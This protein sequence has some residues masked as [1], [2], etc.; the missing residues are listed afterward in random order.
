MNTNGLLS[1]EKFKHIYDEVFGTFYRLF[2]SVSSETKA[3]LISDSVFVYFIAHYINCELVNKICKDGNMELLLS[4]YSKMYYE[5]DWSAQ[6]VQ[7]NNDFQPANLRWYI[8]KTLRNLTINN[9]HLSLKK[10][11]R[12]IR[13][14]DALGIGWFTWMKAEFIKKH[15]LSIDNTY[16]Q[17]LLNGCEKIHHPMNTK[18]RNSVVVFFDEILQFCQDELRI[19][20]EAKPIR[21][22]WMKRLE[23]LNTVYHF[24]LEKI[25]NRSLQPLLLV[26]AEAKGINKVISQAYRQC[27]KTAIGFQHGNDVGGLFKDVSVYNKLTSYQQF[28]FPT[29]SAAK[30]YEK[31]YKRNPISQFYPLRCISME[32][33]Y[34]S[35][36]REKLSKSPFPRNIRTVMIMGHS[37][38]PYR[39]FGFPV[40]F[41]AFQLDLELRL[42]RLLKQNGY[43]I[44]YKIH[45]DRLE[46]GMAIFHDTGVKILPEHFETVWDQADAYIFKYA[47]TTAFGHALCTN[48]SVFYVNV[49]D[50]LWD[51]EYYELLQKRC[52][53]IQGWFDKNNRVQFDETMLLEKLKEKKQFPDFGFVEKYMF[54]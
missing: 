49:E 10:R 28:A 13:G 31:V 34:Y 46:E 21:D 51:Q 48:R 47:A 42:I 9:R 53:T 24:I 29:K 5:P 43:E 1:D 6:S 2:L 52:H 36:L 33:R 40:N 26:T 17:V 50:D 16:W 12:M 41:F 37:M 11:V 7:Y 19:N 18:T 20:I 25:S 27:S 15:D 54:P 35:D 14:A 39:H 23:T 44:L 45:P 22:C 30:F 32:S 4:S 3:I 38:S 8:D